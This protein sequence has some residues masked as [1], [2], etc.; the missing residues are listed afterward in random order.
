MVF[1]IIAAVFVMPV[2][3]VASIGYFIFL[4]H[5]FVQVKFSLIFY[6][7]FYHEMS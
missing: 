6:F 1:S 2:L 4:N 3:I 7:H 5:H